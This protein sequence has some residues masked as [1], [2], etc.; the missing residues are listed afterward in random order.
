MFTII[1]SILFIHGLLVTLIGIILLLDK[2]TLSKQ[3]SPLL[4]GLGMQ[5]CDVIFFSINRDLFEIILMLFTFSNIAFC[6]L[7]VDEL[8]GI[9]YHKIHEKRK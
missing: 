9:I 2:R 1:Q 3:L 7:L 8:K 6:V 5:S 4:I